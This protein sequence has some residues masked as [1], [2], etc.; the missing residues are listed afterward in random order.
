MLV[1]FSERLETP[2][3]RCCHGSLHRKGNTTRCVVPWKLFDRLLHRYT[4]RSLVIDSALI[5]KCHWSTFSACYKMFILPIFRG[6]I[7]V[8]MLSSSCPYHGRQSIETSV[9]SSSQL[10]RM[11]RTKPLASA[12]GNT[13]VAP[14]L[15]WGQL[16]R[17]MS[18]PRPRE[19]SASFRNLSGIIVS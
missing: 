4:Y 11:V 9:S 16:T 6:F 1:S 2:T 10:V 15:W 7:I 18:Q 19:S 12:W 8:L 13:K 3:K 14:V 17:A 5:L